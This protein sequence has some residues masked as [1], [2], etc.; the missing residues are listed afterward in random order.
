MKTIILIA[1]ILTLSLIAQGKP[2]A[3][4]SKFDSVTNIIYMHDQPRNGSFKHAAYY[5]VYR[6]PDKIIRGERTH[7]IYIML[8]GRRHYI[9]LD[10][11]LN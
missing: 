7:R 9:R 4:V 5:P 6:T 8:Q 2:K 3:P 11:P 10:N 1:S